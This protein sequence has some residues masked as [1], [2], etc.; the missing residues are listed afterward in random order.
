ML[1]VVYGII[2]LYTK[3]I[4]YLRS[5]M[6]DVK[7]TDEMILNALQKC[8]EEATIPSSEVAEKLGANPRYIK[9]KLMELKSKR[10]L[11]GKRVGNTWCFRPI[12]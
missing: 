8:I 4:L 9:D 7:Y 11:D 5:N 6:S 10:L 1:H 12:Q 3:R 2:L